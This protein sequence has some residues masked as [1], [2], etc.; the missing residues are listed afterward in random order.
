M[1]FK[2]AIFLILAAIAAFFLAAGCGGSDASFSPDPSVANVPGGDTPG[3]GDTGG[4]GDGSSDTSKKSTDE[5]DCFLDGFCYKT[6]TS[7]SDCP[8]GFS[9]VMHVCTFDC[10]TDDECG[11]GGECND[12]GLCEAV[13]GEKIP[14][15]TQNS[16]CGDGRF[17]NDK[18]NCEQVPVLFGCANDADCPTGQYC[19]ETTHECELFPAAGVS[20]S[21]DADC[22]GNYYCG[23]S[24]S[25][26]QECRTDYQCSAGNACDAHG[27]CTTAGLPVRL[28]SFSFNSA[29]ADTDP[30]APAIFE[31]ASYKIDMVEV[32]PSGRNE[33]L[34][35]TSFRLTRSGAMTA[36]GAEI[37][38]TIPYEG[39]LT[40]A[41]GLDIDSSVR[42]EMR[43]YDSLMGGIGQGVTNSHVIYAEDHPV[44]DVAGGVFR[45]N[46]GGGTT[47]NPLVAS[48]PI[49]KLLETENVYIELWINGERLSPRQHIGAMPAVFHA[50]YA[51]YADHLDHL[52]SITPDSLPN[53]PAELI[54]TGTL[55]TNCIPSALNTSLISGTPDISHFPA[56][57]VAN[58]DM[59]GSIPA[60][61]FSNLDASKI[62]GGTIRRDSLPEGSYIARD[63]LTVLS[64]SVSD[65]QM[66]VLPS[67]F[68]PG[69]CQYILA[70]GITMGSVEG[71]DQLIATIDDA[72]VVR[73]QI[74]EKH[75]PGDT[76]HRMPCTAN[77]MIICQK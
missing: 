62:V 22:P 23:A 61:M 56:I 26:E 44:V 70:P 30:A 54:T 7:V 53:Y 49:D 52:P 36:Q 33:I 32:V 72:N 48:L 10:Q 63:N 51:R 29:G 57:P 37:P 17:C 59:R 77:Y 2:I 13:T 71:I 40:D 20:C 6:C 73:C 76:T 64:G 74:D 15:C 43:L 14:A 68:E 16:E 66:L 24:H 50:K 46:I 39:Y 65:E 42:I 3:G 60:G 28:A 45:L 11:T 5:K 12:A 38:N 8:A 27:R 67:G 19:D 35:S 55:P 47:L 18:G 1:K 21:A 69:Q 31:S 58:F 41:A 34:S 9:C 4:S 25:C 75:D